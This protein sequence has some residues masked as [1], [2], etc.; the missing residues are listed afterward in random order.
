MN[1]NHL[2]PP[3]ILDKPVAECIACGAE[4]Y[5]GQD[6]YRFDESGLAEYVCSENCALN[7]F[8]IRP[9]TIGDDAY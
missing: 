1:D 4:L 5:A 2:R 3:D 8:D 7:Y 9:Y 6:V